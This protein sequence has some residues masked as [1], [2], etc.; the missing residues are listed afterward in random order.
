VDYPWSEV[1]PDGKP[2]TWRCGPIPY[3]LVLEDAPS[4]APEFVAQSL[5]RITAASGF[6]FRADPPVRRPS[7]QD[8]A[9]A[10]IVVAWLPKQ[11]LPGY[12]DGVIGSGGGRWESGGTHFIIGFAY[13]LSDWMG[14]ARTDFGEFSAGPVLLHELGHALGL[15]HNDEPHSVMNAA[16]AGVSTFSE[17]ER[18]ALRYLHQSCGAD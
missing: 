16:D 11:D 7:E 8:A 17:R 18:A 4:G 12:H 15:S 1:R 2:V 6:E 14:S 5:Q 13:L 10:G 3:R 9:Y